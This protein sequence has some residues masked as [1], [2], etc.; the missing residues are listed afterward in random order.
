MLLGILCL[1]PCLDIQMVLINSLEKEAEFSEMANHF[2]KLSIFSSEECHKILLTEL[3]TFQ[4]IILAAGQSETSCS[5][6]QTIFST[7][8][9]NR[10]MIL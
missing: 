1:G 9:L 2:F 4:L 10:D 8:I 5:M 7:E 3:F 6:M